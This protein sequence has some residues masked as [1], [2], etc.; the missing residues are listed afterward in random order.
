MRRFTVSVAMA[1]LLA[2]PA[3]RE[4]DRPYNRYARLRSIEDIFGLPHLGY[5]GQPNLRP[6]GDDVYTNR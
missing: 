3:H 2:L 4:P 5:A 6:S 1:I